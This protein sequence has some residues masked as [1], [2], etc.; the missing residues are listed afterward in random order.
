MYFLNLGAK[1]LRELGD[2][3]GVAGAKLV[4]QLCVD[5]AGKG[6]L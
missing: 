6:T 2:C 4:Y 3:V 1:G 5:E